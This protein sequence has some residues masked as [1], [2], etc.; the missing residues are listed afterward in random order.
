MDEYY[1]EK[2]D[3]LEKKITTG[4]EGYIIGEETKKTTTKIKILQ[5][6]IY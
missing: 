5:L 1:N 6:Q 2:T 3:K 4:F